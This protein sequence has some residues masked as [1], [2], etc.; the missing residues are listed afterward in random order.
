MVEGVGVWGMLGDR[1]FAAS[2]WQEALL[3][4]KLSPHYLLFRHIIPLYIQMIFKSLLSRSHK[5]TKY[6]RDALTQV[7]LPGPK[8]TIRYFMWPK[9][10]ML[11]CSREHEP[12]H[13][14]VEAV[15]AAKFNLRRAP[16]TQE[17]GSEAKHQRL[18]LK[19]KEA[20]ILISQM[21]SCVPLKHGWHSRHRGMW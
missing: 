1:A 6:G 15:S 2:H 12:T 4:I 11:S 13:F 3:S 14:Q 17:A 21:Q 9:W 20:A 5:H 7:C 8:L 18:V 10:T 16:G 19:I